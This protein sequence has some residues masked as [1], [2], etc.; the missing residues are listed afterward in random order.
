MLLISFSIKAQYN[1]NMDS[2]SL[3][4][5]DTTKS[6]NSRLNAIWYMSWND[7]YNNPDTSI[8]YA[9]QH[10]DFAN[11]LKD[12][13]HLYKLPDF[14]GLRKI[15]KKNT[16]F[17]LIHYDSDK[18]YYGRKRS[19]EILWSL[20]K[21]GGYFISD[22]ISDN[23]AFLSFVKKKDLIERKDFYILKYKKKYIGVVKK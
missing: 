1:Y 12:K 21:K 2:L 15:K 6:D 10:L 7:I 11:S 5:N 4:W 19:Y 13:W 3:V 8:Y 22:D 9:F 18:S 20:L 16:K 14:Q 17:D 23:L